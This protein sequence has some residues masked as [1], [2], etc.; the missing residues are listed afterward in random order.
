VP[1]FKYQLGCLKV[2]SEISCESS[3]L[4][5]CCWPQCTN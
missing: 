1:K 2:Q 3:S 5:I 4:T